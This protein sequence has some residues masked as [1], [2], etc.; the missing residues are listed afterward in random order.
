[1]RSSNVPAHVL[2][3]Q[4]E[5]RRWSLIGP[6]HTLLVVSIDTLGSEADE[7]WHKTQRPPKGRA[8]PPMK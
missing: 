5:Q 1:M 8:W 4:G 6:S 7:G 3:L 2:D